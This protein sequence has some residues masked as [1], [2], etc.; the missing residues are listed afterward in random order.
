MEIQIPPPR[1]A[2]IENQVQRII[3]LGVHDR[4]DLLNEIELSY[5][6]AIVKRIR[7][8]SPPLSHYSFA[9]VKAKNIYLTRKDAFE[10]LF[11]N[12]GLGWDFRYFTQPTLVQQVLSE[13]NLSENDRN[14]LFWN[15][16]LLSTNS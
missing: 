11:G 2:V 5:D 13:A 4:E 14:A 9:I 15:F 7:E 1:F 6:C 16:M 10:V 12:L 3:V 8:Y